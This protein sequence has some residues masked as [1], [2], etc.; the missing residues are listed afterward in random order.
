MRQLALLAVLLGAL[1]CPSAPDLPRLGKIPEATLLDQ[2]GSVYET[3][4]LDRR[5]TVVNFIFTSCQ[6]TCPILTQQMKRT[7]EELSR[8]GV[9]DDLRF[10]SIT[11]DPVTDQP[12]VLREYAE[13]FG[14]GPDWTFVTGDPETVRTL[15]IQGF[16]TA[17]GEVPRDDSG[18]MELVHGER[19][20]LVD[21][22]REIRGFYSID[23]EGQAALKKAV[24]HLLK[25]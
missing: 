4:A 21:Q 16:K 18:L 24:R 20:V 8:A 19:F 7:R 14:A 3:Q 11:V 23:A 6:T 25:G 10:L 2:Q 5:V 15:V 9:T 1:A 17:M 12:E 13:S 22:N